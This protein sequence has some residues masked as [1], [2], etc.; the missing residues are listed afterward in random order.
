MLDLPVKYAYLWFRVQELN[1]FIAAAGRSRQIQHEALLTKLR[2]NAASAFGRDHGFA[3]IRNVH[4]FRRQMPV[5]NYAYYRAYIE[6]LKQGEIAAMFGPQTKILMLALTSGTT[7]KY[8]LV[9][10]TQEFFDEY[11]H[12]WNLWG[13]GTYRDHLDLVQKK[14]LKLG[15]N[16]RQFSTEA[17]IPCGA[18]SGLVAET[19]PWIARSRF[20]LPSDV[21]SIDDPFLKHYT[22]L[23][24]SLANPQVGMVG[25]ANPSTLIEFARLADAQRESLIRDIADGTLQREDELPGTVRQALR[26]HVRRRDRQ[27]ARELEEIVA[28]T[29]TL[30]P[31]DF[32]PRVSV[33]AVWTGGSVSVYLPQLRQYY[34][35]TVLRDHGLNASEARMTLPLQ[36]G[37][38]A[39]IIEFIH[40]FFEFIPVAEHDSAQPV[41]LEAHELEEG[42]DYYILLTTSA[43]FYRYDIHDVVRC[44]GF[45]GE[46]PLLTFLNKGAH[47]SSITGEKLSEFQVVSAVRQGADDLQLEIG[48]FSVAPVMDE[49][50]GYVL[51]V[52]A[53]LDETQQSRLAE[54]VD[55]NLEQLNCEYAEKRRTGRLNPLSI[56]RIPAGTWRGLRGERTAARGN[57]EEYKHPCLVGDLGFVDRL[58]SRPA[59]GP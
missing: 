44:V 45:Q 20:V 2:R 36:D 8:K 28:R 7:D 47:F 15:S 11:R 1:R 24:L 4:D 49:R 18:I 27:R 21:Y 17:G 55:K 26:P 25:T 46:A 29:G 50:P 12:G 59:Q 58:L 30:Y 54:S 9:P 22:A 56:R 41:V 31:R 38:S 3:E 35:E 39:G 34:G 6:R 37:T 16:W 19:A 53:V 13:V 14:T 51:L 48:E 42:Q 32:W 10:I 57:F 52:E 33:I 43:G 40:H 23:R 5:T